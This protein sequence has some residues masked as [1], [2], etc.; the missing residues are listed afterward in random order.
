MPSVDALL[1]QPAISRLQ[2]EFPRAELLAAVRETLQCRRDE[3]LS[4]RVAPAGEGAIAGLALAV[5]ERL[6]RRAL[7]NLRRVINATGII[8]HTGLG[9]APLAEAAIEAIA[10]TA[11]GYCNLEVNLETGERGDRHDH[12]RGLLRELTGAEDGVVVN[13]NAA[14][15][16]LS[17]AALAAGREVIVSRGQLVEIGGSYRMPEVMAAAGCR[18]VEVGTTN[19]THLADYERA[20]TPETAVLMHV[21]T[22]NYR[23]QGFACVPNVRELAELAARRAAGAR[24][25]IVIDDLGSGLLHANLA[26]EMNEPHPELDPSDSSGCIGN[27][28]RAQDQHGIHRAA[29]VKDSEGMASAPEGTEGGIPPRDWDE[30]TVIDSVR[31]GADLTLFSG[32]KLLGGPQA[33]IVVGRRESIAA[34]QRHPL[35]RAVRPDKLCLAALEATLRLHRDRAAIRRH[36]PVYAL[37]SQPATTIRRRAER[38]AGE[39]KK[40]LPHGRCTVQA[41]EAFA[42]GGSMPTIAFPTFVVAVSLT[43][44]RSEHVAHRLRTADTPILARVKNEMICFDC[45]TIGDEDIESVA[46][47]WTALAVDSGNSDAR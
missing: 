14:A 5:R 15:T 23:I 1:K 33:G 39:I 36:L 30:P 8:L 11:G 6:Y 41:S 10:S 22:S 44:M 16:Y 19:R 12:V 4:G 27:H 26:C 42:G 43:D 38:L 31:S 35:M 47:A 40:R 32:D 3:I 2:E 21:H 37:L 17:L 34:L 46:S 28:E 29:A 7:P 18:L 25:L 45:R 20:I 24:K 13:N 9:R